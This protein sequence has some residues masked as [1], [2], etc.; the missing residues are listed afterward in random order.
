[1]LIDSLTFTL[2]NRA[3]STRSGQAGRGRGR[4]AGVASSARPFLRR[5]GAVRAL[6][7]QPT[8]GRGGG[9]GRAP[10][11]SRAAWRPTPRR[12]RHALPR[13]QRLPLRAEA[14][15]TWQAGGTAHGG[16][17]RAGQRPRGRGGSQRPRQVRAAAGRAPR[18]RA[19]GGAMPRAGGPCPALRRR[20]SPSSRIL[21]MRWRSA[22][23]RNTGEL[24]TGTSQSAVRRH[25]RRVPRQPRVPGAAGL[26]R[27]R[28]GGDPPHRAHHRADHPG[29]AG[30]EHLP[31]GGVLV[32]KRLAARARSWSGRS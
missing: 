28:A 25:D 19:P 5:G 4:H 10:W 27:R 9:R 22:R 6:Y 21:P 3:A 17:A 7:L 32:P 2:R 23:Y 15:L 8:P 26:L 24:T 18:V 1:M 12:A 30:R 14:Q 31:R 13:A 16:R 29:A 11:R 20:A